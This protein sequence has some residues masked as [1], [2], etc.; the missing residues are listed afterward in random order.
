MGVEVNRYVLHKRVERELKKMT[1]LEVAISDTA[2]DMSS[3]IKQYASI[4]N[5]I[6]DNPGNISSQSSSSEST[7]NWDLGQ[8]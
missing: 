7:P 8:L 6:T 5:A 3:F 4:M 1:P 2:T